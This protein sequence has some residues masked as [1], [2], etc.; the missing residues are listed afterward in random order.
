[1]TDERQQL[2]IIII[3]HFAFKISLNWEFDHF[4]RNDV[5]YT[6]DSSKLKQFMSLFLLGPDVLLQSGAED[7]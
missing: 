2:L 1:M 4:L 5:I 3:G 6:H 7:N